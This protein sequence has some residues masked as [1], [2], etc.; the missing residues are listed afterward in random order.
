MIVIATCMSLH[1]VNGRDDEKFFSLRDLCPITDNECMMQT[2][3]D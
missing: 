1:G 2:A 3:T